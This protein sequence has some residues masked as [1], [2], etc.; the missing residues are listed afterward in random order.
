MT[1]DQIAIFW[2]PRTTATIN[3]NSPPNLETFLDNFF[4]KKKSQ[5][6]KANQHN[7]TF[8]NSFL[9]SMPVENPTETTQGANLVD[10]SCEP[11]R[12]HQDHSDTSVARSLQ[13]R[14]ESSESELGWGVFVFFA[15]GFI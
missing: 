14:K 9:S 8:S 7:L 15:A 4:Q 3:T 12:T 2:A 1:Y 6:I 5:Q 11:T 13:K 10:P